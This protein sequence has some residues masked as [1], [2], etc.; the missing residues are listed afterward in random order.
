M[1]G[2]ICAAHLAG[3]LGPGDGGEWVEVRLRF[4]AVP[5][6]RT[7]LSFGGDVE[8]VSPAEVRADLSCVAAEVVAQYSN[9]RLD[10][11]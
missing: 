10:M 9:V 6:A 3:P 11:G 7:L 1:F 2:R 8:V 5:A 4:A